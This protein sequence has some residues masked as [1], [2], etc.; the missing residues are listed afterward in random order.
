MRVFFCTIVLV[1][2]FFNNSAFAETDKEKLKKI[3][4]QLISI[5]KLY[6]NDVLDE[7]TY[8]DSKQKLLSKKS[9]IQ[10]KNKTTVKKKN[11]SD[12]DKQIAVIDKLYADGILTEDEYLKTKKILTDKDST[13]EVIEKPT[14][15]PLTVNIK[16]DPGRKLY[17]KAE[18][19]FRGYRIY[20]Y[21]QGGIKV[22]RLSDNK[23]LI[24]ITD[25]LKVKYYNNGESVIETKVTKYTPPNLEEEAK[26]KI[27]ELKTLGKDILS[28]KL[29]IFKKKKGAKFDKD[30][31]KLELFIEGIKILHFEGRYVKKYKAFFYQVL[32]SNFQ[33]FH[34]YLKLRGKTAIALN[35]EKFNSKIDRAIRKAKTKLMSEYDITEEQINAI[36]ERE[37]GKATAEATKEAVAD[38]VAAEV[39]AAIAQSVG[40]AMSEGFVSAIEEATGEAIEEAL[41]QE[42]AAAIDEAIADAVAYG[43]Q[44]A[45]VEAGFQA[46]FDTLA[47][48][49]SEADAIAAADAACQAID[50]SC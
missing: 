25:N 2:L 44:E 29:N 37:T 11:S 33:S 39:E 26:E 15:S 22:V 10:N 20:T 24:Q 14:I 38:A 21:R 9:L 12:L 27:Q 6:E 34:F 4:D 32:T 7:T 23:R 35:M 5:K 47:A 50:A 43:I 48:G 1:F 8:E 36:I 13:K 17:E 42:L 41:Q 18:I 30:A 40:D 49:G 19:I 28:G 46:F 45:A 3:D 31:H 16:E